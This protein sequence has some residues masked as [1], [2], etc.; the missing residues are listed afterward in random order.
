MAASI[1][2]PTTAVELDQV[3]ELMRAFSGW[4]RQR[5]IEDIQL[6]DQYFDAAA[7]EAELAS[8]PGKYGAPHGQLLL[9]TLDGA[10]AGCVALRRID[11][12]SCEMKRMFVH[13][14]FQGRGVGCALA[15]AIIAEARLMGYSTMRLDTSI[16]QIEAQS[17]YAGLGFR[18]IEPYYEL[19]APLRNWLVFMEL[20]LSRPDGDNAPD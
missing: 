10:A 8:L 6:V 16:R 14:R 13:A 18:S 19:P 2:V 12:G 17:L 5:N 3:R 7:F 1:A 20:E 9:A 4:Q 11:R 15:Q